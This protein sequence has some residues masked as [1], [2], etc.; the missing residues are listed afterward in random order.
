MNI[1]Y[2]NTRSYDNNN[3]TTRLKHSKC[4][5]I[6]HDIPQRVRTSTCW[7]IHPATSLHYH[8]VY[9]KQI[10]IGMRH[11]V[12]VSSTWSWAIGNLGETYGHHVST[13]QPDGW[14]YVCGHAYLDGRA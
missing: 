4:I 3:N 8:P 2:N 12:S 5:R 14:L 9:L 6:I 1:L 11:N 13:I 10:K 7:N